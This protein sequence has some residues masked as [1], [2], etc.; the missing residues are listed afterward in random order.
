MFITLL[1][2]GIK[3]F[4][5]NNDNT[6]GNGDTTSVQQQNNEDDKKDKSE[7]KDSKDEDI[8]EEMPK[9]EQPEPSDSEDKSYSTI[10][11][12]SVYASTERSTEETSFSAKNATDSKLSTAWSPESH[13]GSGESITLCFDST[14]KVHGIKISNGYALNSSEYSLNNRLKRITVKFSDG[15]ICTAELKDNVLSMQTVEFGS[16]TEC[17]SLTVYIDSV[18]SGTAEDSYAYISEIEVF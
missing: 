16:E 14:R 6:D 9:T 1:V 12:D 18:Y 3:I 10:P 11:V 4:S 5:G 8:D 17:T 13:N 7:V 15:N 2:F